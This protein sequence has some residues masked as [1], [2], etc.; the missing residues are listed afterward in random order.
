MKDSLKTG[1]KMDME[2][3]PTFQGSNMR[4][5]TRVERKMAMEFI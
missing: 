5:N 1:K 3:I 4:V 2:F